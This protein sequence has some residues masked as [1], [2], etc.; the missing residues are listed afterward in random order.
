M[1]VCVWERERKREREKKKEREREIERKRE[2]ERERELVG[3]FFKFSLDPLTFSLSLIL[4]PDDDIKT[5]EIN[6]KQ[7]EGGPDTYLLHRFGGLY[8]VS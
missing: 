5:N 3:R 6:V 1:C 7:T 8:K 4:F 2:R